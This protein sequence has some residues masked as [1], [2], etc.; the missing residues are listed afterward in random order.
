[1]KLEPIT[2]AA[3]APY[4]TLLKGEPGKLVAI[5]EVLKVGEAPGKH[6]FSILSPQPVIGDEIAITS[7]ERHPHSMQSFVPIS[8]SRWPVLLVPSLHDGT[9]DV[10]KAVAFLAGPEDAICISRNVWHAGLT[11]L[12]QPA[13]FAMLM[14]KVDSGEDGET[15]QLATPI[16]L[17]LD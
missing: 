15:H 11:V 4:A 8:V 2:T 10:Q 9:P 16:T 17:S 13:E 3:L 5:P 6:V 7:L 14:W 1:M 12:D